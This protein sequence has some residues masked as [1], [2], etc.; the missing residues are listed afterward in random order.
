ETIA[1]PLAQAAVF[2]PMVTQMIA[3]GEETGALDVMLAKVSEF[4]DSEVNAAVDGLT[5]TIE[6]LLILFLGGAVG[7]IVIA[8]YLPIF[9]VITMIK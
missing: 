9:R 1:R 8:L 6:P 5:S 7:M 2:P 4:Y 3:I